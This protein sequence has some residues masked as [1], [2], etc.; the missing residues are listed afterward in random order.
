MWLIVVVQNEEKSDETA[1]IHTKYQKGFLPMQSN[2]QKVL[3]TEG[4][5]K[6][7]LRHAA[8]QNYLLR[9]CDTIFQ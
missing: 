6:R 4:A 2:S 8:G 7:N 9:F 5:I 1:T 3:E